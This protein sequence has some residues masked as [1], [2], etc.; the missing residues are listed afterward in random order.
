MTR[1][2]GPNTVY[3]SPIP[4]RSASWGYWSAMMHSVGSLHKSHL[5][6]SAINS[7]ILRGKID[8]PL[9][10]ERA[11]PKKKLWIPNRTQGTLCSHNNPYRELYKISYFCALLIK[12]SLLYYHSYGHCYTKNSNS[13]RDRF[14]RSTSLPWP[15]EASSC[16]PYAALVLVDYESCLRY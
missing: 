10:L 16:V 13:Y 8:L 15:L 2:Q 14:D 12:L 11:R 3:T 7:S 5:G 9:C 4:I 6:I 1:G